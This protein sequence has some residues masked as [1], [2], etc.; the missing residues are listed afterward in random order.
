MDMQVSSWN[1]GDLKTFI[2]GYAPDCMFVGKTVTH[3]R[4]Q[5]LARYEKNFP[6]K[7]AMG[8]LSFSDIE[9]TLLTADVA[10]V[11]GR[12]HL[13]RSASGGGNADGIYSLV[14][15]RKE[16]VWKIALDHTS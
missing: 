7:D 9:V 1:R 3:G 16:G 11:T 10:L 15:H 6:N 8:V 5:V 14:F 4:D 2:E 13:E 12:F